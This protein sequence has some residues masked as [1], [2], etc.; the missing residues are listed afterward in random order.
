MSSQTLPCPIFK[1]QLETHKDGGNKLTI[2]TLKATLSGSPLHHLCN[3]EIGRTTSPA[4]F[5]LCCAVLRCCDG[6]STLLISCSLLG[7]SIT[8]EDINC[9]YLLSSKNC[10]TNANI[11]TISNYVSEIGKPEMAGLKNVLRLAQMRN[12]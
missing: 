9:L 5:P 4:G 10:S 8:F 12:G 11:Q 7:S 6:Y 1:Y 3:E 2:Y